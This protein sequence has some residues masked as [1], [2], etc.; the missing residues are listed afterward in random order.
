MFHIREFLNVLKVGF[1]QIEFVGD[2]CNLQQRRLVDVLLEV[3]RPPDFS[4]SQLLLLFNH[5]QTI[6]T[7][8][9]DTL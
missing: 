4:V 7:F 2:L 3:V 9:A 8:F 6:I 1:S 5:L